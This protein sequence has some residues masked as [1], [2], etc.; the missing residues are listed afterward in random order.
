MY[1]QLL[2]ARPRPQG[3]ELPSSRVSFHPWVP[4]SARVG[5]GIRWSCVRLSASLNSQAVAGTQQDWA[6]Q[7]TL[8][9]SW[10]P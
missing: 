7:M 9:R 4:L 2:C 10:I 6:T 8:C 5:S 3:C 1:L